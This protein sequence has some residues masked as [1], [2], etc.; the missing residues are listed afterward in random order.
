M[1]F[2]TGSIAEGI[3][4]ALITSADAV[5]KLVIVF[6]SDVSGEYRSALTSNPVASF[7]SKHV[8][9]NL[10][11]QSVDE[12]HFKQLYPIFSLPAIYVLTNNGVCKDIVFGPC[13]STENLLERFLKLEAPP[14]TTG[15][16]DPAPIQGLEVSLIT[17]ANPTATPST[18]QAANSSNKPHRAATAPSSAA[19]V[20]KV[21]SSSSSAT[22]VDNKE[23]KEAKEGRESKV[24]EE[25][26]KKEKFTDAKEQA[27]S[28]PAPAS[29]T[30][31]SS[32]NAPTE[33]KP[34]TDSP[35][36]AS[37]PKTHISEAELTALRQRITIKRAAPA[38]VQKPVEPEKPVAIK[39]EHITTSPPT[40][41]GKVALSI[42]L[43]DGSQ[44]RERF[45][46]SI[47]LADV[48][49]T[50]ITATGTPAFAIHQIYPQKAFE[51]SEESQ[52]LKDLGMEP[53]SSL[54]LVP[55][56]TLSVS[57]ATAPLAIIWGFLL[58]LIQ[59]FTSLIGPSKTQPAEPTKGTTN[60]ETIPESSKTVKKRVK[61]LGDL[62][63][64]DDEKGKTYNGNSTNQL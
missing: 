57:T 44:L 22:L 16:T 51:K 2:F 10:Q 34:A 6:I 46:S 23:D 42:R 18:T 41:T 49:A 13:P 55:A 30:V 63:N 9:L 19:P 11:H 64:D 60:S 45:D 24:A 31:P 36:K 28:L 54:Y 17:P 20:A 56:P 7:L 29:T 3:A 4:Q 59:W 40:S 5:P 14:N 43:L 33:T 26:R 62:N 8:A 38:P 52:T 58:S 48:R 39:R 35:T 32:S 21:E 61:T 15:S 25:S 37:Q 12:M 50:L 53:S 1:V 27:N 47:T